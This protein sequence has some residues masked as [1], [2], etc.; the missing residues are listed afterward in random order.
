MNLRKFSPEFIWYRGTL[1]S[2]VGRE[3]TLEGKNTTA[4]F[5]VSTDILT[6]LLNTFP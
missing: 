1:G 3:R 4:K 5:E 6:T 2:G